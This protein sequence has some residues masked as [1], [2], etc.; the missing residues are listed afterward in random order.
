M[1]SNS[2]KEKLQSSASVADGADLKPCYMQKFRLYETRSVNM[3]NL[4]SSLINDLC[5]IDTVFLTVI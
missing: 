5:I 3:S 1:D 2:T 4:F